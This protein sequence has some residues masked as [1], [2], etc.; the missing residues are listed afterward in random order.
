[1]LY[2]HVMDGIGLGTVVLIVI[3]LIVDQSH[4]HTRSDS[5]VMGPHTDVDS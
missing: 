5:A 3:I 1:M 2:L 4:M